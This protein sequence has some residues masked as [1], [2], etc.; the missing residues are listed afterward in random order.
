L[1]AAIAPQGLQAVAWWHAKKGQLDRGV[2][3][4]QFG[5]PARPEGRWQA[6][7]TTGEP[8]LLSIAIGKTPYHGRRLWAD[9]YS[10]SG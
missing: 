8:Q 9:G 2:E 7:G 4:L 6:A 10:S 1:A 3:Q 5:Q